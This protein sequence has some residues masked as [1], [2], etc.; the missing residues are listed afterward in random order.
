MSEAEAW[1]VLAETMSAAR[2]MMSVNFWT[3]C[4]GLCETLNYLQQYGL[5]TPRQ[6]AAMKGRLAELYGDLVW[7]ST[8]YYWDSGLW[9]PRVKACR[10][11]MHDALQRGV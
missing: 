8:G 3:T 9:S 6:T 11:L 10:K 1:G 5:I 2:S 4:G 7:D